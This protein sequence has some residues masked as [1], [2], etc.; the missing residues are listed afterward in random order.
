MQ[1]GPVR[2]R[3]T[4]RLD[5]ASKLIEDGDKMQLNNVRIKLNANIESFEKLT[6]E[7]NQVVDPSE[8]E[9]EITDKEIDKETD[10]ET[11]TYIETKTYT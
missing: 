1:L 5:E 2:K 10:K 4:E 3:L 9:K 11:D 8:D 6:S 7:L